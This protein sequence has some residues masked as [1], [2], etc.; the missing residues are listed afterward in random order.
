MFKK[1]HLNQNVRPHQEKNHPS[2]TKVQKRNHLKVR[3]HQVEKAH[4]AKNRLVVQI[5]KRRRIKR[6]KKVLQMTQIQVHSKVVINK[7]NSVL[8]TF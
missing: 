4:Q 3:P 8:K 7:I 1:R 2:R 5:S 6:E